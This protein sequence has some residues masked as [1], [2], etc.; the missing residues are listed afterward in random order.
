MSQNEPISRKQ[1]LTRNQC[2]LLSLMQEIRYG[3][4]DRLLVRDGEGQKDR[5][6]LLLS[7]VREPLPTC[8]DTV[9]RLHERDRSRRLGRGP[10]TGRPRS[11]VSGGPTLGTCAAEPGGVRLRAVQPNT[12]G[13]PC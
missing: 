6:P 13:Q 9:W 7:S 1:D 12:G 10:P 3:R 2:G 5:V 4:I 11:Q 8:L